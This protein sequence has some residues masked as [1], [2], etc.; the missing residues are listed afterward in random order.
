MKELDV[1][2][3]PSVEYCVDGLMVIVMLNE[4]LQCYLNHFYGN[5]DFWLV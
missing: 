2:A 5:P 3:Y 4:N 1:D